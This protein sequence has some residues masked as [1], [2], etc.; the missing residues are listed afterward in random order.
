MRFPCKQTKETHA[1]HHARIVRW[2]AWRAGRDIKTARGRG[3]R[4]GCHE[5]QR[6]YR[7]STGP[8]ANPA[9]LARLARLT[10]SCPVHVIVTVGGNVREAWAYRGDA[11]V[12]CEMKV[13]MRRKSLFVDCYS[14]RVEVKVRG[15]LQWLVRQGEAQRTEQ[16]G[17][18]YAAHEHRKIKAVWVGGVK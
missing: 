16:G 3:D 4:D 15:E 9:V 6:V 7:A 1:Q 11:V 2:Y 14:G 10:A 12:L 17:Y 8:D 5:A 13:C 18:L